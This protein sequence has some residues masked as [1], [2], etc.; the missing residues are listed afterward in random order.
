MNN[1]SG[2]LSFNGNVSGQM[3]ANLIPSVEAN[4]SGTATEILTSIRVG[5]IIYSIPSGGGG[6][7]G[8][9]NNYN[10]LLNKPKINNVT[11]SG[12]LSLSELGIY[13]PV[14]MTGATSSADGI[15]GY[16]PK[17]LI[18]DKDKFLK[19]DG[20]WSTVSSGGISDILYEAP[21][22]TSNPNNITLVHNFDD[23]DDLE[24]WLVKNDD[25]SYYDY[26]PV[27]FF[28]TEFF[29]DAMNGAM[30]DRTNVINISGWQPQSQYLR[31]RVDSLTQLTIVINSPSLFIRKIVGIKH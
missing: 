15:A 16:A 12:E 26:L 29:T 14:V 10:D 23:Y 25:S 7:G 28:P 30:S 17:P 21:Y 31:I 1:L 13:N 2:S 4:P 24:F 5:D 9:T 6:G 19:G 27:S 3:G 18:A 22:L 20:T 11:L 8:G